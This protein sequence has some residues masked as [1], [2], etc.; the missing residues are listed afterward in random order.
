MGGPIT[1]SALCY[2]SEPSR[3]LQ[4]ATKADGV[5]NDSAGVEYIAKN[6]GGSGVTLRKANGRD[7]D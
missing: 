4:N 3:G 7:K 6:G 5:A 2:Q 1:S